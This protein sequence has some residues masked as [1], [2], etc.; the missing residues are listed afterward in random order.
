MT[1][2]DTVIY[3][4]GIVLSDISDHCPVFLNYHNEPLDRNS[5]QELLIIQQITPQSIESFK[6]DIMN[7]S[8]SSVNEKKTANDAYD[9]FMKLFMRI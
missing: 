2:I 7:Q 1:N 9:D 4:A 5:R 6:I 8:W 3:S